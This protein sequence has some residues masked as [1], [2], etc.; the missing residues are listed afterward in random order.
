[1]TKEINNKR[2]F[3]EKHLSKENK[4]CRKKNQ[5]VEQFAR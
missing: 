3:H 1:M 5:Q 2:L 4:E